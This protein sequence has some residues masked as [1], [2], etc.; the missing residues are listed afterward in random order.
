MVKYKNF[1]EAAK[2]SSLTLLVVH[3]TWESPTS[4]MRLDVQ[5][6]RVRNMYK[7]SGTYQLVFVIPMIFSSFGSTIVYFELGINTT[8]AP[9]A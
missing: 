1:A 8:E 6:A 3:G 9:L 5:R 7:F 4:D 2:A